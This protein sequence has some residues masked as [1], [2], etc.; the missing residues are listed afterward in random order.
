[1]AAL[2]VKRK[3]MDKDLYKGKLK[4]AKECAACKKDAKLAKQITPYKQIIRGMTPRK[5]N[6]GKDTLRKLHSFKGKLLP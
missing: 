2:E 5:T 3:G 6:H 4:V 1:M